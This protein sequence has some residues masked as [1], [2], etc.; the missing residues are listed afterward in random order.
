MKPSHPYLTQ[1]K[2]AFWKK[3]VDNVYPLDIKDWYVKKFD[4]SGV[5][6]ATAG[7]CFAQ[8]IG[9]QLREL[10]FNYFDAEPAP[11]LLSKASWQDFGFGMYSARYGN[12]YT[13][14][15]FLQIL[16][17]SHGK[18]RPKEEVWEKDGGYIDPF[19]PTIEPEPF[20]T[21]EELRS[22]RSYHFSCIRKIL[23]KAEV[24]VYTLGLTEAWASRKDGAV[25]PIA[26]GVSGGQ[27]DPIEHEL[28]NLSYT[29]VLDD[30]EK[31]FAFIRA[32]NPE[33]KFILT[34][35]PVPLMATAS[36][37]NVVV[38]TTYSKSVL[39]AAAGYLADKYE[40]VDY[41]PSYEIVSSHVMRAQFYEPD[42]RSVSIHGVQH[43][44]SHFFSQHQPSVFRTAPPSTEQEDG[45]VICDEELLATFGAKQ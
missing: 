5:R 17:R 7:S 23:R 38:A 20:A 22:S 15:Q 41:F 13:S 24:F 31:A 42:M 39:R 37:K 6:V 30:M 25:F 4:I 19:R 26:P 43:V 34:V 18:F 12:V 35:S 3:T 32:I 1:A 29:E 44:M 14:R 11:R 45:D 36:E 9:R 40:F 28:V 2:R 21:V 33:M 27:Y 10:G 16:L 8:H